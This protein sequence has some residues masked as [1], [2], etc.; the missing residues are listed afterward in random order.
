MKRLFIIGNG[1]DLAHKIPTRYLDYRAFL[2]SSPE[3]EDFCM[4]MEST[5]G[6]GKSTDYWWRDFE[7][8]LGEGDA[9]ETDFETMAECAIDEMV[10]DDGEEMYDVEDTLRYHFEPYYIFMNQLNKTVLQWVESI[11]INSIKP[12]FKRI[13]E[14]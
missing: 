14:K 9:F 13:N 2:K 5:Y 11:D 1:F 7:T 8:N 6:L 12:I 10:T 4:R 3:N